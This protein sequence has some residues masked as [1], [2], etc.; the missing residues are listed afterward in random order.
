[1]LK[2]TDPVN[3]PWSRE[4][5][6]ATAD[7]RSLVL[8]DVSCAVQATTLCTAV[9]G[10][11]IAFMTTHP[12]AATWDQ[13]GLV[14][15][16]ASISC[17]TVTFCAGVEQSGDVTYSDAAN[18]AALK[19]TARGLSAGDYDIDCASESLCVDVRSDGTA[20]ASTTPRGDAASWK[21][22][23]T[24]TGPLATVACARGATSCVLAGADGR[25]LSTA[26][27]GAATP[28]W[29]TSGVLDAF[30]AFSDVDCPTASACLAVDTTGHITISTNPTGGAG[31]WTTTT[32]AGNPKMG[33]LACPTTALCVATA[34]NGEIVTIA[35]PF[36]APS[37]TVRKVAGADTV[38]R[39]TCPTAAL[40][41]AATDAG[42]IV[43]ST[44][45]NSAAWTV[46]AV[47]P[48]RIDAIDCPAV[49]F[50]IAADW[51]LH[52]WTSANPIGGAWVDQDV[53][54]T[55]DAV[56]TAIAC[57]S[58]EYCVAGDAIGHL[59]VVEGPVVFPWIFG[60]GDASS[61]VPPGAPIINDIECNAEAVCT[62]VAGNGAVATAVVATGGP[63][64]I[65]QTKRLLTVPTSGVA[66]PGTAFCVIA[67]GIG[68]MSIGTINHSTLTVARTG[69]GS[70]TV[71]GLHGAI[72]CGA[73]CVVPVPL[74]AVAKLTASPAPG[75]V[76][77]R[78]P[79]VDGCEFS[80]TCYVAV[81]ADRTAT[82]EFFAP[83][84]TVTTEGSGAVSSEPAGISCGQTCT[85]VFG[86]DEEVSLKAIPKAGATFLG[87][88]GEC[89]NA[90][91]ICT[92]S[93]SAD[94]SAT[95]QFTQLR[96]TLS[97]ATDGPGTVSSDPD[98]ITCGQTCT[99][100]FD[101]G[102]SVRLAATPA[103]GATFS[104]WTGACSGTQNQCV[105][106]IEADES[107]TAKFAAAPSPSPSPTPPETS[108]PE[109]NP[110]PPIETQPPPPT[111]ATD[112]VAPVLTRLRLTAARIRVASAGAR[113]LP[114]STTVRFTLSEGARVEIAITKKGSKKVIGTVRRAAIK[115]TNKVRFTG[116]IGRRALKA[117]RYVMRFTATDAAGN[118]SK[119][120][121]LAF[122]VG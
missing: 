2:A 33:D 113:R 103:P 118:R 55:L 101:D 52:V 28:A 78:W 90:D 77:R 111:I 68:A 67:D 58:K 65:W 44:A 29:V 17:P 79:D 34:T 76:V 36:G 70:G 22:S 107:A 89:T 30:N 80:P 48:A 35:T 20:R 100:T 117:G 115:G 27:A 19:K 98:G 31:T 60:T 9:T 74:H 50:C 96:R 6:F 86:I 64:S 63:P 56:P 112:T 51:N 47:S 38:T 3:G 83:T 43:A 8:S 4:Q 102:R 109:T 88:T 59:Y 54:S 18:V 13:L 122:R 92:V 49:D 16:P 40:C 75:S 5:F 104:G 14:V 82:V 62:A 71:T 7:P 57:P 94:R 25:V 119:V 1:M 93:M 91:D 85:A 39:I 53:A 121:L 69:A 97:V 10:N 11:T 45:P 114:A 84:L 37:V 110:P 108:P 106:T 95:A 105:L 116:R 72:D 46:T 87:W 120:K 15:A 23:V 66:C 42:R 32:V 61:V 41:V 81:A 12:S 24:H 26:N 73:T 99:A 21:P